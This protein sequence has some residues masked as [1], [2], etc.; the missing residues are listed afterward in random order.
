M[1]TN[2][3]ACRRAAATAVLLSLAL[4]A[5]G[6]TA[7][8]PSPTVDAAP[9]EAEALSAGGRAEEAPAI[10]R[11]P[12]R[13]GS[14]IETLFRTA[15]AAMAAAG[16]PG[17]PEG[18]REAL[19][20]RAVAALRA[21][22]VAR[23]DLA[24]VRLELA[25]AFFLK[26]EDSLSRRHFERVLAGDPPPGVVRN[27]HRFLAAMRA[28]RRWS[29]RFGF[30]IAPDTNINR[31][32][33]SDFVHLDTAFGR[34]PFRRDAGSRARSGTGLSTW[35]GGEYEHPL[36]R[37]LGLRAGAD[38]ARQEHG[39]RRFDRTWLRLRLGPRWRA[40]AD[41]EASLLAE[42]SRQWT[43]GRPH[44]DDAGVR[45]EGGHRTGRRLRLHADASWKERDLRR[46]GALDGP[47]AAFS[48]GARWLATP[49]LRIRASLG[50]ERE[51]PRS[52]AWR[53]DGARGRLGASM[54]L[55][56]G[57]TL[58]ASWSL[59]RTG[60]AAGGRGAPHFTADGRKRADRLQ[61]L[62]AS[63]LNRAFTVAGFSPQLVLVRETLDT[64]AQARDYDRVRAEFRFVRQF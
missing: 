14:R 38:A 10:P 35:G 12:P 61:V 23:P 22:L 33:D 39:G 62:Q 53:N 44:G 34:L 11:A 24:R 47:V 18:R 30:A 20:D 36:G 37:R 63:V 19:L 3:G 50:H 5:S 60:Y 1:R 51:R 27:V 9:A 32:S 55:P 29:G 56:K 21:I 26:R 25:R 13:G 59:R 43:A 64:N 28:R 15:L 54:V 48:V 46:S 4:P 49:T 42:A 2:P 16:K 8:A 57:F 17:L 31:A 45:I 40:G 52:A 41:T 6:A 7:G 58:G